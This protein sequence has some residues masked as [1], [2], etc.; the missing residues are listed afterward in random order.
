V[1]AN[2][3][4]T[5][6]VEM[7]IDVALRKRIKENVYLVVVEGFQLLSEWTGRVWQQS[8]WKFSRPAKDSGRFNVERLVDVTDYEKVV[9]C[10]YTAEERK[11]LMETIGYI[12]GVG[13]MMERVDTLVANTV[14]ESVHAQLQD[15]VQAKIPTML[16]T[17]LRKKKALAR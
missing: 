6:N 17:S 13:T 9:R 10:N 1:P 8:A 12:K 7:G 15:F 4:H 14:W 11:A 3:P 2:S 16:R 5:A